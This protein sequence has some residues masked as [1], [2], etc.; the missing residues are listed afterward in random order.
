MREMQTGAGG[1]FEFA[2]VS[3][4]PGTVYLVAVQYGE[5]PFGARVAFEPGETDKTTRIETA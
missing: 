2:G 4:D 5:V 1:A 3:T